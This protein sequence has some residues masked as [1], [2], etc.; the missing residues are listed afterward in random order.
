MG[1]LGF[2]NCLIKPIRSSNLLDWILLLNNSTL[3]EIVRCKKWLHSSLNQELRD[4]HRGRG[5][6]RRHSY[7]PSRKTNT[8]TPESPWPHSFK[9]QVILKKVMP[10]GVLDTLEEMS[11]LTTHFPGRGRSA[12]TLRQWQGPA[13]SMVKWREKAPQGKEGCTRD[14]WPGPVSPWGPTCHR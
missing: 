5:C 9:W 4:S 10:T 11:L 1:C 12:V 8:H 14:H 6:A 3:P 2:K 13:G 7:K